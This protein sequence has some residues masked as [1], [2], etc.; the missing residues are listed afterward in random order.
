MNSGWDEESQDALCQQ[1]GLGF[2]PCAPDSKLGLA[3]QT[4]GQTPINGLRHAP[5]GGTNGWYIWAGEYSTSADF[6]SP[7]HSSHLHQRLPEVVMYLELPPGSRFLL[8]GDYVDIW[9]DESL[10]SQ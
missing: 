7:L 2:V 4:L 9:F 8:V 6:F 10:L 1:Y 5:T 3:Y